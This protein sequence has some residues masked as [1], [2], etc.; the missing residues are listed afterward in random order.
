MKD[1]QINASYIC[2]YS[3]FCIAMGTEI[4]VNICTAI[5]KSPH[6]YNFSFAPIL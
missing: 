5:Y 1:S 6:L 3:I 4:Y 2:V